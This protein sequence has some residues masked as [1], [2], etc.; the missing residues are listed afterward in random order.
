MIEKKNKNKSWWAYCFLILIL[1]VGVLVAVYWQALFHDNFY[2]VIPD[3]VYRS[4]QMDAEDLENVIQERSI[5]TVV[6]LRG[7][8]TRSWHTAEKKVCKRLGVTHLDIS[9]HAESRPKPE[10]LRK[11]A[12]IVG[13]RIRRPIL[14]HCK[15]GMDR[16]GL[17]SALVALLEQKDAEVARDQLSVRYGHL[18]FTGAG[19]MDRLLEEWIAWL[20]T[21]QK[22]PTTEALTYWAKNVYV[23]DLYGALIEFEEMPESIRSGGVLGLTVLVKNVSTQPWHCSTGDERNKVK[24]RLWLYPASR[25][26]GDRIALGPIEYPDQTIGPGQTLTVSCRLPVTVSPGEYIL[27]A[28]MWHVQR[29][30]FST[31]SGQPTQ[32]PLTISP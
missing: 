9:L 19:A 10:E 31:V 17:A 6:N 5:K 22:E 13:D 20:E 26:G 2:V 28:D 21:N 16:A 3:Q 7:P 1:V 11:L 24:L 4:A 25:D 18:A 29:A 14:F 15:A 8:S 32:Q 12:Q 27:H 23:Y 30:L